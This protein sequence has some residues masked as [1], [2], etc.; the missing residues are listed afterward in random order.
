MRLKNIPAGSQVF[1]DA[2]IFFYQIVKH[3]NFWHSCE[4]FLE[5]VKKGE[6]QGFTSA[7]VLNELLYKLILAEV[8]QREGIPDHQA[9]GFI[10]RNPKVLEQLKAYASLDKLE[11]VPNL[12]VLEVEAT[13]FTKSRDFM[14]KYHLLP[15]D[16]LHLA[17][18]EH[19]GIDQLASNDTAF[20][21]LTGIKV[22]GP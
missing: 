15:S 10:K 19:Q 5:R 1:I 7:V 22:Y 16:A 12:H 9:Y 4:A 13:D 18:M 20:R 3:P 11:A 2:N 17:V 21:Q 8:A 14:K 6:L